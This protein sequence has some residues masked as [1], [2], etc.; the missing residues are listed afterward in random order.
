MLV[1]HVKRR[2]IFNTP[3]QEMSGRDGLI[4]SGAP[5]PDRRGG[6]DLRIFM[7]RLFFEIQKSVR[8]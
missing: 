4:Q 2:L 5:A 7:V 3:V 8:I 6:V 1:G